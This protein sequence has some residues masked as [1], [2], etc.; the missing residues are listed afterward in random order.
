MALPRSALVGW[1]VARLTRLRFPVLFLLAAALF[2]VDLVVPDFIP[3]ADEVL[4]GLA[5]ALLASWR[6]RRVPA[7]DDAPKT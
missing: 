7:G 4:L 3:F 5:T 1:L 6:T 2:V